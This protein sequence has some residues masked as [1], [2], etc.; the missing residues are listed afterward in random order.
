MR[1]KPPEWGPGRFDVAG[2]LALLQ[3]LTKDME[4]CS[5]SLHMPASWWML[6]Q[7]LLSGSMAD[8]MA[9]WCGDVGQ[10]LLSDLDQIAKVSG[11]P[12]LIANYDIYL[13]SIDHQQFLQ[14][15]ALRDL[16]NANWRV[17]DLGSLL[18]YLLVSAFLD[19]SQERIKVLEVGGGFGRLAEFLSLV[20][21]RQMQYLN[22]DAVPV[23]LMYCYQYLKSRFPQRKVMMF[24]PDQDLASGF[25]F[26]VVPAWHVDKLPLLT[27]D[28]GINVESMQ[29][30]S[31]ELVDFYLD[32]L[33]KKVRN[34]GVIYLVNSREY[35][36]RGIWKMPDHW[37]CEFRHRTPRSWTINHPAEIFRRTA[38]NQA[39]QNMLRAAAFEREIACHKELANLRKQ[40]RYT[41]V[42]QSGAYNFKLPRDV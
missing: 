28:L 20:G 4:A 33:D 18:D 25:D 29:E 38:L 32:Y 17:M 23:S 3:N 24:S 19:L 34:D 42:Y 31:Q 16:G 10:L 41:Q 37:Q 5:N 21:G 27:F 14:G 8:L 6:P 30:M 35:K 40:P 7:E 39:G 26:L 15:I 2:D 9:A 22:I 11:S 1:S 13:R 36:F 12:D